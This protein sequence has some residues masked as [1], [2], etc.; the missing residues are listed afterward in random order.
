V[1]DVLLFYR[2]VDVCQIQ[3]FSTAVQMI[4]R[5][6]VYSIPALYEVDGRID[7]RARMRAHAHHGYVR[8]VLRHGKY[9][10][11]VRRRIARED[12]HRVMQPY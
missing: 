6:M 8:R 4:E 7:V 2:D 3:N 11:D 1:L 9:A 12:L 5:Y 10:L